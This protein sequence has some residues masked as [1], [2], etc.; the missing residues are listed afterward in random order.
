VLDVFEGE[1]EPA[2]ALLE[3]PL[4]ATPHIAGYA[5]EGKRRGAIVIY[6][7]T[8]RLLGVPPIDTSPLLLG[9]FD[10]PVGTPVSFPV[11]GD[12]AVDADAAVRALLATIHDIEATS[13]ELKATVR[14]PDRGAAF[15]AMRRNYERDCGRHELA[16]YR[17][18]SAETVDGGLG[19]AVSGRLAGF[20]VATCEEGANFVLTPAR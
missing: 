3:E 16:W 19:S 18:G 4:I 15:D 14:E 20:G 1:P 5:V 12:E 2:A 6:E 9:G 7:E 13:S 17:V 8:C 10:P 11:S